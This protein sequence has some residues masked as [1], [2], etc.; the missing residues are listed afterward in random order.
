M[1]RY[2]THPPEAWVSASDVPETRP[3]CDV[4]E[5]DPT[6]TYSGLLNAA[7]ERLYRIPEKVKLGFHG[8]S[9]L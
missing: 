6:P 1:S 9:S 2:T 4:Y 5:S 3:S 7:G 8:K